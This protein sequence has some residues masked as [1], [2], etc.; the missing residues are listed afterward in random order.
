MTAYNASKMA[1]PG[2]GFNLE[3][4]AYWRNEYRSQMTTWERI[5]LDVGKNDKG[6]DDLTFMLQM[7]RSRGYG[8]GDIR[9]AHDEVW[10]R[11]NRP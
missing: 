9:N 5:I 10:S 11:G 8:P 1:T 2:A 3:A 6:V 7:S 4:A